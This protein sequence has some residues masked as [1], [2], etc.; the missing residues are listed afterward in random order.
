MGSA[1]R[2]AVLNK[3]NWPTEAAKLVRFYEEL[4]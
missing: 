4:A 3:Y 1:G 2:Q